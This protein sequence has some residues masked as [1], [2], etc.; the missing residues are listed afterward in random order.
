MIEEEYFSEEEENQ[1]QQ[2]T[3]QPEENSWRPT[4]TETQ[5]EQTNA[6]ALESEQHEQTNQKQQIQLVYM[7]RAEREKLRQKEEEDRKKREQ[8]KLKQEKQIREE[9][10]KFKYKEWKREQEREERKREREQKE[11]EEKEKRMREK[12][13]SRSRSRSDSRDRDSKYMTSN[14]RATEKIAIIN[15]TE[16]PEIQNIKIQ[17]LGL[18]KE[19]K[20]ILKPSEKFKN[21]FNFKWDSSDD[22]SVDFNPLYKNKI[23]SNF[24]FGR[25]IQAG[26]DV[27]EQLEKNVKYED[28]IHKFDPEYQKKKQ[29]NKDKDKD[30]DTKRSIYD[31]T[32]K[33]H[34]SQKKFD[35]MTE[36]DW[37]IFREDNDII[38]KG[39][40]VPK[41]MRT[42]EEGELPPYILDAVRRSKYEKPTP[43]QMQ[44]I[45]IGLQRKDLIGISQTGTGK[46]CAF[47]IPLITYLRSLPPMDEEI[48]K[49]GPYA[50]ILIP[51][52]ELAPQI[53]KE[54]QNL[55]SN[56][57]M[58]SL[59][60]VGGK[61]EGNQA[62][63][64]K[65]GCE[66]L[67]G[68][69]GRIK[70][71]LEKNYLVLD[72]VSWVVLDEADKMID[73]N[74]E[75]DVNFILDK[76]RTNMKS[77][78]ENMAVLQ[79]QEA[80]VGEKI[81]RVTHL[82]SATM[83]PNLERL[84]KKYLRSF[85]YIS[86]GEA[87]DAKKDIEQIVDFMSEGQK[88]SRLQKILETAKPPIIIFANEKTAVEKL[89]KILDRWGWQNVIYHGGKTQQQRE[90]AVDGF[91]KGKYDILVATDLGARGL[92][93]DG[94]KMVINFDA[95]KNIKDFIHRTGRTGRA[96][97]RGIAYTFVTNHNEAIMYDLREFLFKNNFDIPSELD[98]HPAAQ[99]KPGTISE[100]VPRSQQVILAQQ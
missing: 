28:L 44:T 23:Q 37:R 66:L 81:F 86:I 95:P 93:V 10:E 82:F 21:I 15:S 98:T 20:K 1:Q 87:G 27:K 100:N 13:K 47:L 61:D 3:K 96:G 62:F 75:Q 41:P 24:L 53:E 77:E 29:E 42:W 34:W 48:A 88:K 76:I 16:D 49:D 92:H 63:K 69:V 99:T 57:R 5:E 89:S 38:I 14:T 84:A 17:Y 19:K 8:Q 73:L 94:V 54:F 7:S 68:T 9:Y 52:R 83:P 55:T 22:T 18:N 78:D 35:E 6:A 70:D 91:K 50:L 36:R 80:K 2:Q 59:V 51:T 12:S 79:E 74:F 65:L 40:R 26:Y 31:V 60:M 58:K 97:K 30:K 90:A 4:Q 67:I 45:P 56:M 72:Q 85:C 71:A 43:I 25:G 32:T 46:T 11:R 64:L 33:D 39:G